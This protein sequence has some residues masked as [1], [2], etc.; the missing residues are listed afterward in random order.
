MEDSLYRFLTIYKKSPRWIKQSIGG[1]YG[2]LPNKFRYGGAYTRFKKLALESKYWNTQQHID[3]QT[4]KIKELIEHAFNH[5][6]LYRRKYRRVGVSPT[7]FKYLDDLRK[8]PFITREEIKLNLAD[9]VANNIPQSK[10][11]YATTSGSSGVPLEF[12]LHKGISRPKEHAFFDAFWEDIGF[13]RHDK[14]IIFRGEVIRNKKRPWYYDPIDRH[15]IVSSY[16]LNEKTVKSYCQQIRK[17]R[18]AFIHGYPF[19]IHRLVQLMRVAGEK[20]FPLKG[21]SLVSESVYE[22]HLKSI[23]S[24]FNCSVYHSYGQAERLIFGA[25][26]P[27]RDEYHIHPEYG[28]MEVIGPDDQEVTEGEEGEIVATGF[29]NLVMPFI[30][31]RTKDFAVK[32][33]IGCSCGRAFPMI[34]KIIGREEEYVFLND[35]SKVPFHNLLAGIHGKTWGMVAKLQCVQ[36]EPGKLELFLV[37]SESAGPAEAERQ[38]RQE[39]EDRIGQRRL[40]IFSRIVDYIPK[41]ESGKTKLFVQKLTRAL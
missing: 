40:T 5:V 17:T 12:Y 27:V 20:P 22:A 18:P 34:R 6:P 19:M 30:R 39:I 29:D 32:G 3:Y 25:N 8:F 10:R 11:L 28:Y 35:G 38:F 26:C 36:E 33:G 16:L 23:R 15:L 37:P 41:T 4:T 2:L 1:M 7:D 21:I 31:Y 14:K 13:R 9:A 24:F